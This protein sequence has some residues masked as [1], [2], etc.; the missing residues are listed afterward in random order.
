MHDRRKYDGLS[1]AD[2]MDHI[3]GQQEMILSYPLK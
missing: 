3:I 2:K 1:E